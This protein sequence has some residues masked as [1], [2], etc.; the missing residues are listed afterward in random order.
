LVTD[1]INENEFYEKFAKDIVSNVFETII[2]TV[3][4]KVDPI[5]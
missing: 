4:G 1:E 5:R 2:N 3:N